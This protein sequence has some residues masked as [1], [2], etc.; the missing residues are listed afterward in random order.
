MLATAA[1][2][3]GTLERARRSRTPAP[4]RHSLRVSACFARRRVPTARSG[5][6]RANGA[7]MLPRTRSTRT[8]HCA[9]ATLALALGALSACDNARSSASPPVS[10]ATTLSAAVASAPAKPADVAAPEAFHDADEASVSGVVELHA[11]NH[12]GVTRFISWS[13]DTLGVPADRQA[14][15]EAIQHDLDAS[16][17]PLRE[18]ERRVV[19]VLADGVAAGK[20]DTHAVDGAIALFAAATSA[21]SATTEAIQKLHDLLTPVERAALVD[22]VAAHWALSREATEEEAS[23]EHVGRLA[24]LTSELGLTTGQVA[25]VRAN[26]LG[27]PGASTDEARMKLTSEFESRVQA[28]RLAFTS[29]VFDAKS[30]A[31]GD[32]VDTRLATAGVTRMARFF[33][34]V[35]PVL[36]ATQRTTLAADMR[37]RA[38]DSDPQ[39]TAPAS[40]SVPVK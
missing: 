22:K 30:L 27:S 18:A 34:A 35:A 15:I 10:S 29:D 20:V 6:R 26:L 12:D 13:L 37:N 24:I 4:D 31:N 23:P 14:R 17:A 39:S 32:A 2:T 1:D 33:E 8:A 19:L 16:T 40:S 9:V 25:N 3:L 5:T 11:Y 38:S 28:F 7:H 21:R 36:S